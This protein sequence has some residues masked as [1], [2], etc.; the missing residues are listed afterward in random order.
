VSPME[1]VLTIFAV[2]LA[3]VFVWP[4]IVFQTLKMGAAGY[5]VGRWRARQR[6]EK[7]TPDGCSQDRKSEEGR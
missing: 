3:M 2:C 7:E 6:I 5:Y 1:T 4:M